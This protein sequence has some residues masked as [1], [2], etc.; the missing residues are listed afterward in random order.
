MCEPNIMTLAQVVLEIF[1]SQGSVGLQWESRKT[2]E[3]GLYSATTSPMEKKKY[4]SS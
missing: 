3:K 2:V 1:C 4:G